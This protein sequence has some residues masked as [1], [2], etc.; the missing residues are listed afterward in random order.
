VADSC[1][2]SACHVRTFLLPLFPEI[3]ACCACGNCTEDR[4]S[5]TSSLNEDEE[6]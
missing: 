3:V 2:L 1:L 5:C 6:C 4:G